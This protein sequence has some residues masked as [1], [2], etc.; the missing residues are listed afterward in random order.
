MSTFV[1]LFFQ[2][3]KTL[4]AIALKLL[5][6]KKEAAAALTALINRKIRFERGVRCVTCA[7]GLLSLHS[8]DVIDLAPQHFDAFALEAEHL[9]FEVDVAFDMKKELWSAILAVNGREFAEGLVWKVY[10]DSPR[11]PFWQK[12][13]VQCISFFLKHNSLVCTGHFLIDRSLSVVCKAIDALEDTQKKA[14]WAHL[15]QRA[16]EMKELP[17]AWEEMEERMSS[18][19]YVC[20]DSS[21]ATVDGIIKLP[22]TAKV[23]SYVYR[24][25]PPNERNRVALLFLFKFARTV[26]VKVTSVAGESTP[27]GEDD[28]GDQKRD[29]LERK[30]WYTLPTTLNQLGILLNLRPTDEAYSKR[31]DS[32]VRRELRRRTDM[33]E[34]RRIR[35]AEKMKE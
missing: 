11:N 3:P 17:A 31:N 5:E 29:T 14:V 16:W 27:A 33:Q 10:L 21:A 34:A 9:P 35:Q 32:R 25:Y 1:R 13:L 28:E 12:V 2:E 15:A 22:V 4:Q 23:A 8:T 30:L 20:K 26:S 7:D 18:S 24:C 19:V 6:H